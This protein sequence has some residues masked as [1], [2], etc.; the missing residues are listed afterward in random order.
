MAV[1]KNSRQ[2]IR[3]IDQL[4]NQKKRWKTAR[5]IF[6]ALSEKLDFEG[7]PAVSYKTLLRDLGDLREEYKAPLN[8][9]CTGYEDDDESYLGY[10]R[11]F[12]LESISLE[13][14]DINILKDA[15]EILKGLSDL[16][17]VLDI[18][19]AISNIAIKAKKA[20]VKK[21]KIYFESH[22]KVD[23]LDF[24]PELFQ[25]V[26]D[27]YAIKIKYQP[28]EGKGDKREYIF[29]PYVLREFRNRWFVI[30]KAE[31]SELLK[32]LAID[33]IQN[34]DKSDVNFIPDKT[35]DPKTYFNNLVGATRPYEGVPELIKIRVFP[36]SVEYILTK[37]IHHNQK[38]LKEEEGGAVIIELL[39]YNTYELKQ[40]L[41]G[42]GDGI[43]V[44]SPE[45]L[46]DEMKQL[47]SSMNK[48]Y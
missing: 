43:Q 20:D 23:N 22:T 38:K 26:T 28:Y 44:L 29:H 39:L 27:E 48:L 36:K 14:E 46:R 35:F 41:L 47:I 4:L 16:N 42:Y 31:G 34:I 37:P 6:E 11:D 33:R 40:A 13:E 1:T 32:S 45:S 25:A 9:N 7:E 12:S 8:F 5:E 21:I 30:G 10:T 19:K 3:F 15:G 17:G 24:L 2:R 18:Q